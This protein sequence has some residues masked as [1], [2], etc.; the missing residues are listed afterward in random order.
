MF[1]IL[2][3]NTWKFQSA[4]YLVIY[5]LSY[6]H[7]TFVSFSNE[8]AV[9]CHSRFLGG[10]CQRHVNPSKRFHQDGKDNL[11]FESYL[12][13]I[14]KFH[15]LIVRFGTP[16]SAHNSTI[17]KREASI[18]P[19]C[20]CV[21]QSFHCVH[22]RIRTYKIT[23]NRETDFTLLLERPKNLSKNWKIGIFPKNIMQRAKKWPQ[24]LPT[25]KTDLSSDENVLLVVAKRTSSVRV[26]Q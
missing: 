2:Q 17:L 11:L 10:T 24:T 3:M 19:L 12:P 15:K 18:F 8:S 9:T 7:L 25:F 4:P 16:K 22:S 26:K 1:S 6:T 23:G 13:S 14:W 5:F 20:T 21:Y